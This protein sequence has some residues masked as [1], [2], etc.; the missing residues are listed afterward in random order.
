MRI[1]SRS[2]S[3]W[4]VTLLLGHLTAAGCG[5]DSSR[6][7]GPG[8]REQLIEAALQ[9]DLAF[10]SD[11][12][13]GTVA[14]GRATATLRITTRDGATPVRTDLWLYTLV[15]GQLQELDAFT[16]TTDRKTGRLLLPATLGG[17]P[18]GLVPADDGRVNGLMTDGDRGSL[19]QGSLVSAIDGTVVVTLQ[20]PPTDP[21]VVVAGVEDQRYAGAAVVLPDGSA[22]AVPSGVGVPETHDRVSYERDV[23]PIILANCLVGCHHLKGP[24]DAALY[25][26]D[27]QDQLV[28]N[29]FALAEETADCEAMFPD[30]AA[31]RS[32]CV[33]GITSAEFL[34]EPGAPALSGLLLR[35]RPDEALGSSPLGLAWFGGGS[36]KVRYN[37]DYG[38]RRMPS[39]T[40]SAA[41]ADWANTPTYFDTSPQEYQVL[42]DWVAQGALP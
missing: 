17:A 10:L 31:G 28:N 20:A 30:D 32:H 18:S 8:T 6:A 25:R 12:P 38:D 37:T 7:G 36:N 19:V 33:L 2:L 34:V 15:G 14:A 41:M 13:D 29:N 3:N 26:M 42:Y 35:A 40:M 16:A 27:T 5:T 24:L 11:R 22:G 4:S 23:A 9:V 1:S 39:T 21:I